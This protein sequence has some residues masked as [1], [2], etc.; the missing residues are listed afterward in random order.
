MKDEKRILA[1]I[2]EKDETVVASIANT[3]QNRSY[4]VTVLSKQEEALNLLKERAF[5][6]AIVGETEDSASVFEIMRE[7]VAASPMTSMILV[8]DLSEKEVDE[9][10]EGYG[11]LGHIGRV[12]PSGD[13]VQLLDSL[14]KILGS[15]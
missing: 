13:L 2:L 3:L 15:F 4:A 14:E 6:L 11:I 12:V 5:Q 9:R 1:L 7:I 10:A 8:T